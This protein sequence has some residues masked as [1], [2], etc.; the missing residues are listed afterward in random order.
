MSLQVGE[1]PDSN[2]GLQ[3][4]QPGALPL[5]HP[6]PQVTTCGAPDALTRLGA[7]TFLLLS[8]ILESHNKYQL[9]SVRTEARQRVGSA[10]QVSKL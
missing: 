10:T 5:S 1:M 2:P 9:E 4:I 3:V 8:H 7:R 6:T